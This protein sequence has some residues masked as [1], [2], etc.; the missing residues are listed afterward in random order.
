MNWFSRSILRLADKVSA[1]YRATEWSPNR[2]QLYTSYQAAR[3]DLSQSSREILQRLCMD[4]ECNNP[5]VNRMADIW[6]CYTVGSGLQVTP[7]SSDP[8]WNKRAKDWWATWEQ[9][10]DINSRQ[11]FSTLMSLV[12]RTWMVQGGIFVLFVQ[13][14]GNPAY[15]RLQLVE[16]RLCF[17]PPEM[18]SMEGVTVVDGC[19]IDP[20]GR[21]IGYYIADEDSKGNKTFNVG[22]RSATSVIHVFEPSRAGQYRELPLLHAAINELRDLDDLH[23]LEMIACKDGAEKS[24]II[25]NAAGEINPATLIRARASTT[26]P[27]INASGNYQS[28]EERA[29][30]TSIALGGRTIALKT[31]EEFAQFRN[32]RPSV[33]TQG[34][35][36]YKTELACNAVGIPYCMVFPE[37]MQGTVYRGAL[38]MAA[39]FFGQ[40]FSVINDVVKRI[41]SRNMSWARYNDPKLADAP[42]DWWKVS[43]Q[44]PRACNVDVGYNSAAAIAELGAGILTPAM[45]YGARGLDWREQFDAANEQWAYAEK[46]GLLDKMAKIAA[47]Q[48]AV[49]D[50]Q[51]QVDMNSV[52]IK[53]DPNAETD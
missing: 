27:A 23:V 39:T 26:Q 3:L 32:E 20:R 52:P 22:A 28:T 19:Q 37:S 9:F 14:E 6:E 1:R 43:V 30:H 4:L 2:S 45:H 35:W 41:Y 36:R 38:D 46:I 8:E 31:G 13:G 29:Q 33:V 15:P 24:N 50:P 40:R 18:S 7:M 49:P 47:A 34:Y 42:A 11:S 16:G 53:G 44:A 12:S 48:K 21:T 5:I 51:E 17:T 10:P 25:K